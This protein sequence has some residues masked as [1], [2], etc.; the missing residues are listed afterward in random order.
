M[1]HSERCGFTLRD[2]IV[3]MAIL[4]LTGLLLMQL[5]S[6]LIHHDVRNRCF[7]NLRGIGMA[8]ANYAMYHD[9]VLPREFSGSTSIY[10]QLAP[11][12]EA[13]GMDSSPSTAPIGIKPVPPYSCPNRREPAAP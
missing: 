13:W 2:L 4:G 12:I 7:S 11:H 6:L 8:T 5:R 9:E 3:V 10:F 1:N